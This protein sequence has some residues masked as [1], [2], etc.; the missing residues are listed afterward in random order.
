[1][2]LTTINRRYL[3]KKPSTRSMSDIRLV[4]VAMKNVRTPGN[5]MTSKKSPMTAIVGCRALELKT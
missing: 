3:V 4:S 2:I 1:M 5:V